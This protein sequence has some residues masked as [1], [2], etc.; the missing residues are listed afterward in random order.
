MKLH[1]RSIIKYF[2][3]AQMMLQV[4]NKSYGIIIYT[5]D[6]FY[7]IYWYIMYRLQ[8]V[9]Q[10]LTCLHSSM[11]W[12]NNIYFFMNREEFALDI[13]VDMG[14]QNLSVNLLW[15]N[16]ILGFNFIFPCCWEL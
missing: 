11:A 7:A 12:V 8:K 2:P 5:S 14:N 10:Q 16:F 4:S 13:H 1:Q 3:N 9:Y 15:F 6:G